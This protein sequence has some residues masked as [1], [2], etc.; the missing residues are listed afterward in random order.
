MKVFF[1]MVG[2]RL[3]QAEIDALAIDLAQ[4]GAEVVSKPEMA[5]AIIVNTCCV[6]AKASADSRKMIRHYRDS[7]S[8]MVI[9][10]G[11]WVSVDL[12]EAESIS[13]IAYPNESKNLI[14]TILSK[15]LLKSNQE[16]RAKPRLGK[17]SRTRGFVKVQDGCNNSC[18]FCLTTI[19]RGKSKS[20]SIETVIERVKQLEEMNVKEVVLT[21]V[22]LGS[23]GKDLQQRKKLWQIVEL[24]LAETRVPRIRFSSMEP[25]DIEIELI[26]LL[27]HPR[28]CSHLH[29][30]LQSGSD[31]ILQAMRRPTTTSRFF[32]MLETIRKTAPQVAITTDIIAGF[33]G[34]TDELFSESIEFIQKCQFDGGHV[35][36]FSP[37]AGTMAAEMDNQVQSSTIKRRSKELISL[38]SERELST[39]QAMIGKMSQVLFESKSM[40]YGETWYSGFT[41]NYLRVYCKSTDDLLNQIKLVTIQAIESRKNLVALIN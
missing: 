2:C 29:I 17:R 24:I 28:I 30:P 19:A 20:E 4:Q 34:E 21:G 37:M 5:D 31:L 7:Y 15:D 23:W 3:N 16:M 10:T 27:N 6:T 35:F 40:K 33:P 9:S 13:Q 26:K 18:S 25:W 41:E 22:Q 38:F 39:K 32:E 8:G 1:D 11:C 36:S 14:P 12:D